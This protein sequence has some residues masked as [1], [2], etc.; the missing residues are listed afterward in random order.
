M[1]RQS[2]NDGWFYKKNPWNKKLDN[3]GEYTLHPVTLP[4]DAMITEQRAPDN[5]SGTAGAYYPGY[6][7]TYLKTFPV[8]ADYAGKA[9]YLEFE[10]VQQSCLVSVNGHFAAS[11]QNAYTPFC[12]DLSPYLRFGE[13]NRVTV[14]VYSGSQP[15]ARWYTGAGLYRPV[16]LLVG[17]AVHI[18]HN[19]LRISTPD[20]AEDVSTVRTELQV[21]YSGMVTRT[22]DVLTELTAPDGTV[23]AQ[24]IS[25]LTLKPGARETL[26]QRIYV[27][28]AKL[29]SLEAP[30]LYGCTVTLLEDGRQLDQ[31]TERFGIR[32]LRIDP[33]HGLRL[34][35]KGV[36]LRGACYH[37]DNGV[38][39][40]AT[41]ARAE[42]RRVELGKAAGFNSI[43]VS[44]N[45]ASR[46]L[47]EACDRLGV[48][49]LEESFDTWNTPKRAFDYAKEFADHWEEDVKTIVEKDFNHPSVFM[50]CIGNE[51]A[52]TGNALG[53]VWNRRIANKVRELDDTRFVTNAINGLVGLGEN[54]AQAVIDLG[55]MDPTALDENGDINDVMTSILGQMNRISAEPVIDEHIREACDGLDVS[56]YNYMR[57]CY[58]K[59]AEAYPNRIMFGSETLPPEID[60]NWALVKEYP[61]LLGDYTWTGWDYIGEAGIGMTTYNCRAEFGAP[62][63]CYLAYC[64]DIN[65][66]GDRRPVSYFREIV[67]GLRQEPYIAI[68]QPAHY[69]DRINC[70]IWSTEEAVSSWTWPGFEGKRCRCEVY[71]DGTSVELFLN[72]QSLGE[73]PVER[74]KALFDL[75]YAPGELRA[76][77]RWSDG[78]LR[79][80]A[81][82]TASPE[83]HLALTADRTL[84]GADGQDLAFVT[85]SVVD[86]RGILNPA[87]VKRVQVRVE[88]AG[89]LQG[90]GNADPCSLEDFSTPEHDTFEGRLLAVVRAVSAGEIR[91]TFEADGQTWTVALQAK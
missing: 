37:H 77:A 65:L 17:G 29:W 56:G 62:W 38:L 16:W 3:Q 52:E 40:A 22:V 55:Y 84:L 63:P 73:K 60:L 27:R 14:M 83:T 43:R 32:E 35:G 67:F 66:I 82:Q 5:P 85:A 1:I 31:A 80:F 51:I 64:G 75:P 6:N 18:A 61:Q 2:F 39:G 8:P 30:N 45:P 90:I 28:D 44:H 4:H 53:A 54:M 49:V 79:E 23:A 69:G 86:D 24:E 47:L 50:Y 59:F 87:A 12:V 71:A 42:A 76:V 78:S 9:V 41:F 58:A 11:H 13:E 36:L 72:G 91:V 7:Y 57:G 89:V 68:Q 70:S 20:V 48:L 46:A 33:V 34:N 10:G 74:F 81:L 21:A 26:Y 25:K 88:G 15:A 19:G